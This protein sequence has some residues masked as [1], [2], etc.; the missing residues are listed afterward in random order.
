MPVSDY[1]ELM[2]QPRTLMQRARIPTLVLTFSQLCECCHGH[3][4]WIQSKLLRNRKGEGNEKQSRENRERGEWGIDH[5]RSNKTRVNGK[6]ARHQHN[7]K[8]CCSLF[9]TPTMEE[10]R[11]S[12]IPWQQIVETPIIHEQWIIGVS[13]ICYQLTYHL[14]TDGRALSFRAI[15]LPRLCIGTIPFPFEEEDMAHFVQAQDTTSIFQS[16]FSRTRVRILEWGIQLGFYWKQRGHSTHYLV[17][18]MGLNIMPVQQ[19]VPMLHSFYRKQSGV[20]L[21]LVGRTLVMNYALLTNTQCVV[22]CWCSSRS[23]MAQ[24]WQM[25][26]NFLWA[27][28]SNSR[29]MRAQVA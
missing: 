11:P 12:Q 26:H 14:R 24:L 6:E 22:S 28:S 9:Q 20:R 27:G 4:P 1:W 3:H 19:F 21:S 29:N 10:W 13:T 25:V 2:Q 15:G 8:D 5:K 23:W 17:F 7:R 16:A 18:Q